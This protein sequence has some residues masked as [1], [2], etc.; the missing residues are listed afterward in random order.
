[1]VWT[2]ILQLGINDIYLT[3]TSVFPGHCTSFTQ[4]SFEAK[5][6]QNGASLI[7][8]GQLACDV[9]NE[10]GGFALS[11]YMQAEYSGRMG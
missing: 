5:Q 11:A 4:D 1:M 6:S 2:G 7:A 9:D 3:L 10:L 8:T